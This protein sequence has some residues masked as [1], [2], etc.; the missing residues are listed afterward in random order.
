MMMIEVTF[1]SAFESADALGLKIARI[2]PVT[3]LSARGQ[4]T[5]DLTSEANSL[6]S[7]SSVDG[8]IKE[9]ESEPGLS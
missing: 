7:R 9:H 1:V 5:R 6:F 2:G 4:G 3:D 8:N